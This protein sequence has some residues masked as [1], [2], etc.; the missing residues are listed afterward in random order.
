MRGLAPAAL[1]VTLAC[2]T[3]PQSVAA[4]RESIGRRPSPTPVRQAPPAQQPTQPAPVSSFAIAKTTA[5]L[6]MTGERFTPVAKTTG[7]LLMTG[8]RFTPVAKTT[9]RL[10][11]TGQRFTPVAKTTGG[12]IMTGQRE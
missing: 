4:Q 3:L 5:R 1:A 9:G 7:R 8:E 11:M 12:L 2:L 6:V 10:V